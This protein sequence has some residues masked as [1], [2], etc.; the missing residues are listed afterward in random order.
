[1]LDNYNNHHLYKFEYYCKENNIVT[2]YILFYL[3][4]LFQLF[5][6]VDDKRA[7]QTSEQAIFS[8]CTSSF[9]N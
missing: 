8:H 6:N 5:D 1:M 7:G 4:Y 9:F 2:F 3:S